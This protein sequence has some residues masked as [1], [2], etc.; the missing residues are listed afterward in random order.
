[1]VLVESL[2]RFWNDSGENFVAFAAG[3]K[4]KKKG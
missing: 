2:D 1:M 4:G 3:C